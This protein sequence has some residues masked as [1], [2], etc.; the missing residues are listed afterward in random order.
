[1]NQFLLQ[2]EIS[3]ELQ[4]LQYSNESVVKKNNS[5]KLNS[6]EDTCRQCF[7]FY[8]ILDGKFNWTINSETYTLYPGVCSLKR[9]YNT[10]ASSKH[11]SDLWPL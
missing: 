5:I 9:S 3:P 6:F 7:R 8:Y 4:Q 2:H 10:S 1:M 11:Q